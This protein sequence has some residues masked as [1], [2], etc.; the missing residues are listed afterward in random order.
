MTNHPATY[1]DTKAFQNYAPHLLPIH[2][3]TNIIYLF[4]TKYFHLLWFATHFDT[5]SPKIKLLYDRKTTH[6]LPE[7]PPSKMKI[8]YTWIP[9]IKFC[10]LSRLLWHC[11][12]FR[13]Q[14]KFADQWTEN[15]YK[16]ADHYSLCQKLEPNTCRWFPVACSQIAFKNT[17]AF[18]DR[19]VTKASLQPG[20]WKSWSLSSCQIW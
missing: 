13:T 4:Q 20:N 9:L 10:P 18:L 14:N 2:N 1:S 3:L 15:L 7:S 6:T 5:K 12:L 11:A 8:I 16:K 19:L 17:I